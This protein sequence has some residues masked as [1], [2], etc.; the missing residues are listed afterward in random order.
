MPR[1]KTRHG[2]FLYYQA[3]FRR[4]ATKA[5]NSKPRA[6]HGSHASAE[7]VRSRSGPWIYANKGVK[8]ISLHD[9]LAHA[10][11]SERPQNPLYPHAI[12]HP[13]TNTD[14]PHVRLLVHPGY[15]HNHIEF[16]I[17]N[18]HNRPVWRLGHKMNRNDGRQRL[19]WWALNW[20]LCSIRFD[21]D[22]PYWPRWDPLGRTPA[23]DI[24]P[25]DV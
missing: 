13:I 8:Q 23:E 15:A 14:P 19:C 5:R 9:Y 11:N 7:H 17:V 24:A 20:Y 12:S 18:Y 1:P 3:K 10:P 25:W 4:R 2:R 16:A 22:P 21:F 6:D